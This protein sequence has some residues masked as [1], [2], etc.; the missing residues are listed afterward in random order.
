ML[1][2]QFV[3]PLLTI[4]VGC[5]PIWVMAI[6]CPHVMRMA[7][8]LNKE[9]EIGLLIEQEIYTI[10]LENCAEYFFLSWIFTDMGIRWHIHRRQMC[11]HH[12]HSSICS[13]VAP[14]FV[15]DRGARWR[16]G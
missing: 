2:Y 16:S 14:R 9:C 1:M 4:S 13:T 7:Y 15:S 8:L 10:L 12:G 5:L 3:K 6:E 11:I